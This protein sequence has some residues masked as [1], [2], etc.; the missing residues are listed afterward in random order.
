MIETYKYP[1]NWKVDVPKD[2][3][4]FYVM[5]QD[6][7]EEAS[8]KFCED[9]QKVL[10]TGQKFLPI[11]IDSY[12]GVCYTLFGMLDFIES[13][14]SKGIDVFTVCNS[15]AMSCGAVLFTCGTKRFASPNATFM[16][17]EVSNIIWGKNVDLQ[18][19]AKHTEAINKRFLK[20]MDANTGHSSGY[21]KKRIKDHEHADLYLTAIQA[22]DS[23]L[24]THIAIPSVETEIK[25]ERN[26]TW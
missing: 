14:K 25:V 7:T 4:P 23:Q 6:F 21:W 24:A 26:Y 17:H 9:C 22:K 13:I 11:V 3:V 19:D 8:R 15:K 2:P 20:I 18:N 5:V 1:T 12:G 16:V 10:T